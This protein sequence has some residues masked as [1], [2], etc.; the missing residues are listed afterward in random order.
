MVL[1]FYVMFFID[2]YNNKII[3]LKS[4]YFNM[5]YISKNFSTD[6][7]IE[8]N[9]ENL[10]KDHPFYVSTPSK[11]RYRDDSL[12]TQQYIEKIKEIIG[13]SKNFKKNTEQSRNIITRELDDLYN[14]ETI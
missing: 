14:V 4:L 11:M 10:P 2:F 8:S 6:K 9:V 12:F 1:W 13:D 5:K 7:F 3:R